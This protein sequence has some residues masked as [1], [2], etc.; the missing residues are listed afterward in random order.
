MG[1]E[2]RD[3]VGRDIDI[4]TP[5]YLGETSLLHHHL[6]LQMH[7]NGYAIYFEYVYMLF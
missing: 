1:R 2:K 7:I 6:W 5:F 3:L 4:G